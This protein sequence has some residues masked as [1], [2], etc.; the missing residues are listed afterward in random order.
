MYT[1]VWLKKESKILMVSF[2]IGVL[3]ALAVAAYTFAYSM[4]VQR[5]IADNVIRFHV[6]AHDN[7]LEEQ[8]LKY[9]VK[10]NI[11]EEFASAIAAIGDIYET[12]ILFEGLLP[13]IRE[14]AEKAVRSAGFDHEVVVSMANVFFPTQFYGSIAFPPGVYEAVQIIIGDGNGQNWWCL[15]FP[16]LCYVDM[17]ATDEG[18]QQLYETVSEEGFRLLTHQEA[19]APGIVVRFRVVEWWQNVTQ[20]DTHKQEPQESPVQ[21]VGAVQNTN[22]KN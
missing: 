12:R 22:H 15:M 7:S 2:A 3:F 6:M 17:T 14:H 1:W 20:P 13:Y 16:P 21:Q 11:L 10:T 18:R 8:N 5:E 19:E 9:Y 4:N